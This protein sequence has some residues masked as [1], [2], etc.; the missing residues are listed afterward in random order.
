M[1]QVQV[2]YDAIIVGGGPAGSTAAINLTGCGGRVLLLDRARFP[3]IKPCG[4]G[5][6]YRLYRR[7]PY[8]DDAFKTVPTNFVHKVVFQSPSGA[9]VESESVEPLY[10][11]VRRFDFDAALLEKCRQCGIEIRE[12]ISIARCEVRCDGVNL[13]SSSGEVFS[14]ELVIGADG[15]NSVIAVHGGFRGSWEP[16]S[17]AIDGTEESPLKKSSPHQDTMFIFYGVHGGFGYGYVFPKA[18]HINFGIGYRLDYY[19]EHVASNAYEK[20]GTFLRELQTSRIVEG[21]SQRQNFHAYLV[22]LGGPLA[23]ISSNR[24]LLAGDAAGFVNGFTAEGI[25]YAMVSG[26]HAGRTAMKALR[27]RNFSRQFLAQHDAACQAEVGSELRESVAI[28]RRMVCSPKRIDSIVRLAAR[29]ASMR[30]LLTSFAVGKISYREL[31]KRA[32]TESLP[33]YLWYKATKLGYSL[34]QQ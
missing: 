33:A 23:R 30:N 28:Q 6:S 25:Y 34:S 29:S 31:K 7:F 17:V 1:A 18:G 22:P 3:R 9:T 15:V 20:H 32:A 21:A 11:M 4:G 10:A 16:S 13:V 5:I 12:G 27:Q 26:E 24:I 14:A 8:L 19:R 2:K